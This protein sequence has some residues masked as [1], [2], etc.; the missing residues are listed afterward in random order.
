MKL[1]GAV[2]GKTWGIAAGPTSQRLGR[3]REEPANAEVAD[4]GFFDGAF[5]LKRLD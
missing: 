4:H 2:S 1:P 3:A 5:F